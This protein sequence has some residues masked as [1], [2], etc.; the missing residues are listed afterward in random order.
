METMHKWMAII[1]MLWFFAACGTIDGLDMTLKE[2]ICNGETY[3][4]HVWGFGEKAMEC[5]V[6]RLVR[7]ILEMTPKQTSYELY[8]SEACYSGV[9]AIGFSTCSAVLTED[10]CSQ[11]IQQALEN[12]FQECTHSV[13]AQ[14][15]LVDCR[16]RY[17]NHDFPH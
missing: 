13:G 2:R 4:R 14:V 12:L 8:K 15:K 3:A 6:N 11:C 10:E 17:E 5:A 1:V 7:N 9:S 16:I